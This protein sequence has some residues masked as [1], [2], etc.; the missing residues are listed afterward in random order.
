MT[1]DRLGAGRPGVDALTYVGGF[2]LSSPG[3]RFGGLSGLAVRD[4]GGLLAVTDAGA[5]VWIDL[6]R[7]GATP[8]AARLAPMRNASGQ[9]FASKGDV[10]AEGLALLDGLALVSFEQDHRVMAFDLAACGAAARAAALP[11]MQ[12][13]IASAFESADVPPTGN[14]GVEALAVTSDGVLLYGVEQL[15]EGASPVSARA[16]EEPPVFDLALGPGSPQL[17]GLDTIGDADGRTFRVYSL[18]RAPALFGEAISVWET[19]FGRW[20]DSSGLPAKL[21]D[22]RT[23]RAA[24][25]YRKTGERKLAGMGALPFNIDN[26]EGIA[27]R[28]MPDGRVRLWLVSDDNYSARQRTLLMAFDVR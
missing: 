7:D 28:A 26:F 21:A 17:T 15:V 3:E 18:H 1:L 2:H 9:G 8:V 24:V 27:A 19:T 6:A 5:F 10:D 4:D 12:G 13:V 14:T 25:R 23:E 16:M 11:G 22:E 20:I